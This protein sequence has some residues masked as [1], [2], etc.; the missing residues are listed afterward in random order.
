MGIKASDGK[1]PLGA[2]QHN[3]DRPVVAGEDRQVY[4]MFD[5]ETRPAATGGELVELK[6]LA[7]LIHMAQAHA[8]F[9]RALRESAIAVKTR[10]RNGNV[11][12]GD[13]GQ[14]Q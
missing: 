10:A 3:R 6:Y 12:A 1:A 7:Y 14:A 13:I 5:R 8:R 4:Q 9:F 2:L 11:A